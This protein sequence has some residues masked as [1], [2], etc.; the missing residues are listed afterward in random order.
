M[1][2]LEREKKL[3]GKIKNKQLSLQCEKNKFVNKSSNVHSNK[4]MLAQSN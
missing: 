4:Q 3:I 2:L 1:Q